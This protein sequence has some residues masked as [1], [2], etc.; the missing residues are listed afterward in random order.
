MKRAF[1]ICL[2]LLLV[3]LSLPPIRVGAVEAA[4]TDREDISVLSVTVNVNTKTNRVY[5]E[6]LLQNTGAEDAEITFALPEI[7]SGI[8]VASL[9]VKTAGGEEIAAPDGA[10]TLSV[11][12]GG[13][14]GVSY[15]YAPKINLAYE[16]T[17]AFDLRQLKNSFNDRIGHLEWTVDMP[18]YEIVLVREIQPVLYTVED[19]RISVVLED[20]TINRALDRICLARTTHYDLLQAV[21]ES[22]DLIHRLILE[23]YRNWYRHPEIILDN[24]VYRENIE[25]DKIEINGWRTLHKVLLASDLTEEDRG[26]IHSEDDFDTFYWQSYPFFVHGFAEEDSQPSESHKAKM[27]TFALYDFLL[28]SLKPDYSFYNSDYKNFEAPAFITWINHEEPVIYAEIISVLPDL[29]EKEVY[30]AFEVIDE[31]YDPGPEPN[32]DDYEDWDRFMEDYDAWYQKQDEYYELYEGLYETTFDVHITQH[33]LSETWFTDEDS[34]REN[35]WDYSGRLRDPKQRSERVR[36][37]VVYE[38]DFTN[39]EELR[40]YL[41]TL[42][43]KALVRSDIAFCSDKGFTVH[44]EYYPMVYTFAYSTYAYDGT[45]AYSFDVLKNVLT[46]LKPEYTLEEREEPLKNILSIPVLTYYRGYLY[47]V[48]EYVKEI[49]LRNKRG[50]EHKITW[51]PT[52]NVWIYADT[53]FDNHRGV[54]EKLFECPAPKRIAEERE[55]SLQKSAEEKRAML[56]QVREG[57]G[58]PTAEEEGVTRIPGLVI[59]ER[60]T[61][62]PTEEATETPIEEST[63]VP[64]EEVTSPTVAPS[65]APSEA[66]E[67]ST[68]EPEQKTSSEASE[69][70]TEASEPGASGGRWILPTAIAA[71]VVALAAATATVVVRKKKRK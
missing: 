62:E 32:E 4:A 54:L 48:E 18:L 55:E 66:E 11:R 31:R 3:W 71:G 41:D 40:D 6:L 38:K 46:E 51:G 64:T 22:G 63:E 43:V 9:S 16:H 68:T 61:E 17:I 33:D 37:V 12:A 69:S 60:P 29:N 19:N 14:T 27:S 8:N 58:L 26:Y 57:L 47:P 67:A 13:N 24:I 20:F 42:H 23:N 49:E 50:E 15:T 10:V 52:E 70:L 53:W 28:W 2:L 65:E 56:K 25:T 30:S 21:E 45:E 5:T 44:S 7:T 34:V 39:P 1:I 59:P 35:E 36:V